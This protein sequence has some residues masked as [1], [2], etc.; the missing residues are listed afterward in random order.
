MNRRRFLLRARAGLGAVAAE[1]LLH[2]QSRESVAVV[3]DPSDPVAS[4]PPSEW[5]VKELQAA[6][7]ESRRPV[8]QCKGIEQVKPD[9]LPLIVSGFSAPHVSNSNVL[10]D[11]TKV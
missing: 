10:P 4:A 3:V 11:G 1:G 2:A 6:L 5:A 8:R 9:E 7:K